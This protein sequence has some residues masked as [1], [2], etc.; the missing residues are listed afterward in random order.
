MDSEI[1]SRI[2]QSVD[3]IFERQIEFLAELCSHPS[4]RGNEQSAQDFMANA[5]AERGHAVDRW[6]IDVHDIAHLP[7]FS[8]VIGDYEDAVNVVGTR[9]SAS[10]R[11]R[12]LILNGHI[13]VVPEGPLDMWTS[14]PFMPR[15]DGRWMTGRGV[16]DMKAGLASNLFALDALREIGFAPAADV[17]VQSVVEEECTGNGALAC[18]QRGYRADAA[19]IPEPFAEKLVDAQVGVLW[20]QVL[21]KGLPTHVAY[22]GSGSNA[23][24]AAVPLIA[25]LH[26]LEE[27]WNESGR[28]SP[29]YQS[30]AHALNLNVGKI[31]G[32][33]WTSSVPAWCVFD[34]RMGLFPGQ[35][36]EAAKHE[37]AK[38]IAEAAREHSFLRDNDP[39]IVWHGFHAE[40]YAL[41]DDKS[42]TAATAI[43]GLE[44]AHRVVTGNEL[45]RLAITATTDARF[46][47]L[48]AGIPAL[49]YG[50][51]A[52]AIHGFNERVDLDSMR[53]VTQATALFI[54]DWCGL[55]NA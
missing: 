54:A 13:D 11:G 27:C 37:I 36:I 24:E 16:G 46:F 21:L 45:D 6:N 38:V 22:A 55:E 52:E 29:H 20:F 17:H 10:R 32:G 34:V 28:R 4:T 19:L 14:P 25:A 41:S 48:Y 15:V 7:G 43:A 49:V 44:R 42:E 2:L 30:H 35:E 8:P 31:A 26:R 12:S 40:G 3:A 39:E 1:S 51:T 5:M 53:R 23:I 47:G 9:R 50:P 18:L 33:D